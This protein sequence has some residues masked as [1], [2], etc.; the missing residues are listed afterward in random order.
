MARSVHIFAHM[1]RPSIYTPELAAKICERIASSKHGLNTICA[2]NE[3]FPN[4]AQVYRWLDTHAEFRESYARARAAQATF[5][6]E[7]SLEIS[8]RTHVEFVKDDGE[9][10]VVP[11]DPQRARLQVDTRKW[12]AA[13]LD[14]KTYGD[15]I[16]V[17]HS[18]TI[19][20]RVSDMTDDDIV[21]AIIEL[22]NGGVL[23]E[24][25][26]TAL[27]HAQEAVEDFTSDL[28]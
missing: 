13:K 5:L 4:P 1:A 7:E 24:P 10:V 17:E 25:V 12:A 15:R 19:N 26:R 18:G 27:E 28:A 3:G 22:V 8:D 23:P 20:L 9:V 6:A 14:P 2:V 21:A 16:G 11:L